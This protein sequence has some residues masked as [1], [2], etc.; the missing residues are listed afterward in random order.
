MSKFFKTVRTPRGVL[1]E[2]LKAM[3]AD[4]AVGYVFNAHAVTPLPY[5]DEGNGHS[6]SRGARGKGENS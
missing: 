2:A 3:D 1:A 6:R 5:H 4:K